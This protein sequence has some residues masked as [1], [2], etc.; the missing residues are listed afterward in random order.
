MMR[1]GVREGGEMKS[2]EWKMKKMGEWL[3]AGGEKV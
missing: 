1:R 2:D 3:K